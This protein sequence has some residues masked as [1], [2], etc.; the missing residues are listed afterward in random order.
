M[1][2]RIQMRGPRW[3]TP[4]PR[5]APANEV[6]T[7]ARGRSLILFAHPD[8]EDPAAAPVG[9]GPD[10]WTRP[11]FEA[12]LDEAERRVYGW[13]IADDIMGVAAGVCAMRALRREIRADPAPRESAARA[14]RCVGGGP[15]RDEMEPLTVQPHVALSRTQ[16]HGGRP[17]CL[18]TP[19]RRARAAHR[20]LFFATGPR[21]E[22]NGADAR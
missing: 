16:A 12:T 4:A 14:Q 3:R 19:C 6:P 9:A 11:P 5:H 8:G 20:A 18:L 1:G 15:S 7:G 2:A 17:S 10:H 21:P 13:A 22:C